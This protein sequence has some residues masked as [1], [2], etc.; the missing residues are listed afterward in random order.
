MRFKDKVVLITGSSRGIGRAT[1]LLF[2]QEGAKVAV[3]YVNSKDKAQDVVNKIKKLGSDAFAIRCD[4]SKEKDVKNMINEVIKK[5]GHI[6]VL[7]NNAGIVYDVPLKERS[8]E[9][10][11]RTIDVN[12]TGIFLC[13]KYAIPHMEKKGGSIVIV[14]STNGIDCFNPDSIDYD[15]TKAGAIILTKDLAIALA[16]KIRV[17]SVAPGWVDTDMNKDLTKEFIEEE[18]KR[19]YLK[20]F[21]KPEEI[22]KTILFL[23]SDDASFITGS[24]LKVDGGYS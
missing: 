11:K 8:L 20:R 12:L 22:A 14:S 6:D 2:A 16:P 21:A 13:S 7:V 4:V 9:Q 5:F 17:N 10:W 19:I 24:I 23:S 3:N 18:T 1:A 15:V